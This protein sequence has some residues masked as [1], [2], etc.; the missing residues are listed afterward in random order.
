[1]PS[2]EPWLCWKSCCSR[3]VLIPGVGINAPR[4]YTPS[5][6][7]V[8]STRLRRSG[9]LKI[10]RNA[11]TSFFIARF[12]PSLRR[13]SIFSCADLLNACACTVNA[14]FSSPSPRIF[15][16]SRWRERFRAPTERFRRDRLARRETRSAS[17]RS[18]PRTSSE[19]GLKIRASASGGAAASGRPQNP[20]GANSRGG[21]AGL[22]CR[23]P[24]SCPSSSPCRAPRAPCGDASRAAASNSRVSVS[25]GHP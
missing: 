23:R 1:M 13:R 8:N 18:Q 24:T 9:V 2:T 22:C 25:H 15:T 17:R 6:P 14:T 5:S 11:S 7:S 19:T 16:P 10:F 4:R 20:G 21:T 3:S 12:R